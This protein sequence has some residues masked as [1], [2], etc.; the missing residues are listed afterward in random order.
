MNPLLMCQSLNRGSPKFHT[1]DTAYSLKKP[2]LC[3]WWTCC[4]PWRK[5]N[6]KPSEPK[7]HLKR[8]CILLLMVRSL[9]SICIYFVL[10]VNTRYLD[11]GRLLIQQHIFSPYLIFPLPGDLKASGW[12]C[13]CTKDVFFPKGE[14]IQ[15]YNSGNIYGLHTTQLPFS[16]PERQK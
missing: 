8:I 12:A 4:I 1:D 5:K 16:P 11:Q 6:V 3:P 14:K 2:L 9:I 7:A 15:T 13:K 10:K